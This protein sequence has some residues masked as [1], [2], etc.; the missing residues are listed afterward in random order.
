MA[1]DVVISTRTTVKHRT[2]CPMC[3][4]NGGDRSGDNLIVYSDD[5]AHCFACQYHEMGPAAKVAKIKAIREKDEAGTTDK[6]VPLPEDAVTIFTGPPR[7][8][9]MQY[10]ITSEE[11]LKHRFVWSESRQLLIYPVYEDDEIVFWCGRN[12]ANSGKKYHTE[13]RLTHHLP[14][15]FNV[16]AE[17]PTT[18]I[19]IVEDIVSAIKVSRV[20]DAMAI[21]SG[22]ITLKPAARLSTLYERLIIWGDADKQR[23][24]MRKR[25]NYQS[26]Y[27]YGTGCILTKN[28][29][30][31]YSVEDIARFVS[32]QGHTP[33]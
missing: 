8:W 3:R 24:N 28:D 9:L 7:N 16:S 13:G 26:L 15:I 31:A 29:P 25:A 20:C 2:A 1:P 18:E 21:F 5:S 6:G 32:Q 27:K 19:V 10:G 11:I 22:G 14:I 12:F 33:L 4:K 17:N 30:K 23:E